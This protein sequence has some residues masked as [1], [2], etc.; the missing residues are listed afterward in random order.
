[1]EEESILE[2]ITEILKE[3][4]PKDFAPH[5]GKHPY[6]TVYQ[7]AIEFCS[8]KKY[9]NDFKKLQIMGKQIGGSGTSS[10]GDSISRY[11]S[12][13]LSRSIKDGKVQVEHI[14]AAQLSKEYINE[15]KFSGQNCENEEKEI[16]ASNPDWG[17]DI[18]LYRYK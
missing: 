6:L 17:Y 16:I 15:V 9:E 8:N 5:F 2:K 14:E 7:I 18:S 12:N 13:M 11:F 3:A 4:K 10:K 1:M